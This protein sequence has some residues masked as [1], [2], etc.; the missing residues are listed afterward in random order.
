ME[1]KSINTNSMYNNHQQELL[2]IG[3][4][5]NKE[6]IT[7]FRKHG[8]YDPTA[9]FVYCDETGELKV[10]TI[11]LFKIVKDK[12]K[13]S[14]YMK[15]E[16]KRI[17]AMALVFAFE[18]YR[19]DGSKEIKKNNPHQPLSENPSS[20]ESVFVEFESIYEKKVWVYDVKR[21]GGV[22]VLE[23]GE[24]IT[25]GNWGGRFGNILPKWKPVTIA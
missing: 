11:S 7:D 12:D 25:D 2:A 23:G 17:Q 19:L 24:V 13:C 18:A 5:I 10:K 8:F 4:D 1:E 14:R 15:K 20:I 16:A 3:E 22:P 9:H 21:L 6:V